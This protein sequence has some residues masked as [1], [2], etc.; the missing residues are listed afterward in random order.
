M[1]E[2]EYVKGGRERRGDNTRVRRRL[3]T[4]RRPLILAI[5]WHCIFFCETTSMMMITLVTIKS[6]SVP[7]IEGLSA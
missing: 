7:L 1:G 5:V 2:R 3:A 4:D 6:C